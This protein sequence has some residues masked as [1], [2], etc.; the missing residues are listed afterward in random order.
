MSIAIR[1]ASNP[2]PLS[3]SEETQRTPKE[4]FLR[5][6]LIGAIAEM[7][8]ADYIAIG[9]LIVLGLWAAA[10]LRRVVTTG[11]A[12]RDED[13]F[14]SKSTPV[15]A[16]RAKPTGVIFPGLRRRLARSDLPYHQA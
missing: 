8:I 9:L 12:K 11:D 5:G 13:I 7:T 4:R 2:P 14:V 10:R 3:L 1:R 15:V 16:R 6:S